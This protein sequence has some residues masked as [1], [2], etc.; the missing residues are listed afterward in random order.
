MS[1]G[2]EASSRPPAALTAR[3]LFEQ[4]IGSLIEPAYHVAFAVLH[5][6]QEAEDAVQEAA[7]TAWRKM[8][9]LR[10][11]RAARPWFF[12]I[13][14]NRARMHQR[15]RWRSVIKL[16]DVQVRGPW[17]EERTLDALD[18]RIA[19]GQLGEEER[20]LLFLHYGLD[21]PL[22]EVASILGLRTAGAK[23]RLY[24]ILK[25][26]RPALASKKGER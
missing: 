13:V 10:D 26:L 19:V 20:L 9:Q 17:N 24:R 5:D 15:G 1:G 2:A 4:R 6:R 22:E 18:L 3:T 7:L 23:T 16:P 14:L 8:G 12:K 25:R 21:L 11:P